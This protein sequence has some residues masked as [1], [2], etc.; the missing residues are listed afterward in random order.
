MQKR[1]GLLERWVALI[2]LRAATLYY[3]DR[4]ATGDRGTCARSGIDGRRAT[5]LRGPA[6]TK[7]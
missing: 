1:L 2:A 6:L 4:D 3:G 5:Y 7:E